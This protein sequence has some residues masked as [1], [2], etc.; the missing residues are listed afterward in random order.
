[1]PDDG[2]RGGAGAAPLLAAVLVL[3]V[4]LLLVAV[5]LAGGRR[6]GGNGRQQTQEHYLIYPELNL[7]DGENSYRGSYYAMAECDG[8]PVSDPRAGLPS[9]RNTPWAWDAWR[10]KSP[11]W[12]PAPARREPF[13]GNGGPGAP[14]GGGCAGGQ[15]GGCGSS[16]LD[17]T[18]PDNI[19]LYELPLKYP[20]VMGKRAVE[21]SGDN[22]CVS[23]CSQGWTPGMAPG[24]TTG[25]DTP[26]PCVVW[27]R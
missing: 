5:P 7:V 20:A 22:R 6:R 19:Q 8:S 18:G 3:V 2:A 1:M 16:G 10:V 27:C 25:G 15:G 17:L 21:W 4:V 26:Q 23:Y 9:R 14:C 11:G 12:G 24:V 13:C